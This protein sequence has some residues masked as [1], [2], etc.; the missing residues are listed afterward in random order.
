MA[1]ARFCVGY[2]GLCQ[3]CQQPIATERLDALPWAP[4][5][6]ECQRWIEH[7][8]PHASRPRSAGPAHVAGHNPSSLR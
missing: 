7:A 3:E 2:Y 5:C 8:A 4:L 6:L 1:P